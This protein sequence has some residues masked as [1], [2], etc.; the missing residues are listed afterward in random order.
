M[1][2]WRNSGTQAYLNPPNP[3]SNLYFLQQTGANGRAGWHFAGRDLKSMC[4]KNRWEFSFDWKL[5]S[6]LEKDIIWD[7]DIF[8]R[9]IYFLMCSALSLL[10]PQTDC[11]AA[12]STQSTARWFAWLT[13]ETNTRKC[14]LVENINKLYVEMVY[15]KASMEASILI[16]NFY[17]NQ[18]LKMKMSAGSDYKSCCNCA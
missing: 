11:L 10:E 12:L 17:K 4:D 14:R 5:H 8:G 15:R 18:V 16:I 7:W 9:T 13:L 6:F 2:K 3:Y 1:S